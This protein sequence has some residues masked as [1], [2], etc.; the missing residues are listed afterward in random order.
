M[1]H[2]LGAVLTR[3]PASS[4]AVLVPVWG[5]RFVSDF[6]EFSLPTLLAPGNLPAVAHDLPFRVIVL[7]SEEDEDVIRGHP[8]WKHVEKICTADI[9]P[10]DDL[11]TEG[12]YSAT[13]TLALARTI[14]SYGCEITN[15]CFVLWMSD[16]LMADGSLASVMSEFRNGASAIFAGNFQVTAEDA[17]PSIRRSIDLGS[18]TLAVPSR[19]LLAWSLGY[20]HPAT[21][22]NFVNWGLSHNSDTN[23]LF[24]RFD[25]QTVIGRFYLMHPIGIRPDTADFEIGSSV[26]YSFVPEMCPTGRISHLVDS[27]EY[28]VVELQKHDHERANLLP[29]PL[30]ESELA[31]QLSEW[32]TAQHRENA[33]HTVVF[34]AADKPAG[35]DDFVSAADRYIARI[36]SLLSPQPQPHRNH[37]YWIG[38]IA[39]NRM[40]T[41]R[42]LSREDWRFLLDKSLPLRAS[43]RLALKLRLWIF[44]SLPRVTRLHPRWPD[45]RLLNRALDEAVAGGARLLLIAEAPLVFSRWLADTTADVA[46]IELDRFL[47]ASSAK[48]ESLF[49]LLAGNFTAC[50]VLLPENAFKHSG[51][52]I[53]R[54]APLM[55][56]AGKI[57]IFAM[58]E[59]PLARADEFAKAFAAQS[60]QLLSQSAWIA[61]ALYVPATRTR[62]MMYRALRWFADR[63]DQL[64][65][66]S[67][68]LTIVP[69]C[70]VP[71]ALLAGLANIANKAS[72]SPSRWTSSF[73]VRLRCPNREA[74]PPWARFTAKTVGPV[75]E[76]LAALERGAEPILAAAATAE[77]ERAD[78]VAKYNFVGELLSR[79]ADVAAY[80]CA[81]DVGS[82]MVLDKVRKLAVY[83]P[84]P[85]RIG[86]L[87]Q[88]IFDPWKFGVHVHDIFEGPLPVVHDAIYNL[89]MLEYVSRDDEDRYL[90]NL[91]RSLSRRQDILI[92]GLSLC[93]ADVDVMPDEFAASVS[94][95]GLTAG[96][97][98]L[99]TGVLR[100]PSSTNGRARHPRTGAGVK[101]SL[102]RHFDTVSL[103]SLNSGVIQAGPGGPGDYLFAL[104]SSKKH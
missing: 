25:E 16:Y 47:Y 89:D 53:E 94:G 15:T 58:N 87:S 88:Q 29:G 81:D 83:D 23:R 52:L 51:E 102:E 20:L 73:F 46:T 30:V 40:R 31:R 9:E 50:I 59:R 18:W 80:G 96:D 67:P 56:P 61:E 82:K 32:T 71:L 92:I 49:G 36:R 34:H 93:G 69:L 27:D 37:H 79:R 44:G 99:G 57:S 63:T 35:L 100:S 65:W 70:V 10:I 41:G 4:G 78:L 8:A 60:S 85:V 77:D 62:W 54:L 74:Q 17:I 28:L 101:A 14:K 91:S 7:T 39:V 11:I 76:K 26:D 86:R 90:G 72:R 84:D 13:I 66:T 64:S 22:A 5:H 1:P 21:V 38:S 68:A 43:A 2:E 97:R 75:G 19:D 95:L 24:W 98:P 45:Y 103:F 55:A 6:L 42:A 12:N 104:C 3:P 48:Y 33:D